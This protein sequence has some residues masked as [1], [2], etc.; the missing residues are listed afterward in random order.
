MTYIDPAG[1]LF[2]HMGRLQLLKEGGSPPPINIEIDL[3][4]RC[5]LGCEWCHFAHTHTKGP[6]AKTAR[7]QGAISGGDLMDAQLALRIIDELEDAGVASITWTGGGEP[8]LHPLFNDIVGYA[9]HSTVEQ[10]IY[11]NGCHIDADRADLLK[12][13]MTF[14]FVS[15]D[16]ATRKS[17]VDSK[18][19]DKFTDACNGIRNL[20]EAKGDATIGIG[21]LLTA[22]NWPQ[23]PYMIRLKDELGADYCQFRPTILF[24]VDDPV[25]R[26]EEVGWMSECIELLERYDGQEGIEMDID[27]MRNYQE[28]TGHGYQTCYWSALQSVITP[29]GKMWQC[30]NKREIAGEEL[31]DLSTESFDDIWARHKPCKVNGK[32][33]VMCRGHSANLTL[34]EIMKPIKHGAFA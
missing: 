27:R 19:V 25:L 3:S 32:C 24:D 33:R 29:N 20:V 18:R 4:N 22:E 1:K 9:A 5:S 8:T 30:V 26:D 10:G 12:Q 7:A 23:I 2:Q 6:L 15:L 28:W 31:G 17:Y 11:T 14:V 16:A 34:T 13:A 21:F